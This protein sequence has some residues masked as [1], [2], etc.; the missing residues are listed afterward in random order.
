MAYVTPIR[1]A[2]SGV[3]ALIDFVADN[4]RHWHKGKRDYLSRAIVDAMGD[5]EC[6]GITWQDGAMVATVKPKLIN[7]L[8]EHGLAYAPAK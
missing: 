6:V 2:T 3:S 4:T 8:A 5:R 1:L 7:L